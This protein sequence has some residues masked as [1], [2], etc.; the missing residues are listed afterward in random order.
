MATASLRG[1]VD[2]AEWNLR[3]ELAAC[4]RLV[5]LYGMSDLIFTHISAKLEAQTGEEQF[6]INPYGMLFNEITA[7]SLVR[8]D[9]HGNTLSDTLLP[10]NRAGFVIHGT[11]HEARPDVACVL[12]THTRA[13]VAVSAQRAG[14]RPLSQQATLVLGS[15][16]YHGYEGIAVRD[17]ERTSLQRDLG[18]KDFMIL[19]NHGLLTVGRTVALAFWRMYTLESACRIQIDALRD[20]DLVEVQPEVLD[21]VTAA[22]AAVAHTHPAQLAWPALLRQLDHAL[23]GYDH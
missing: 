6:L 5:A 20:G 9:R 23:P 18:D 7:S 13:G 2:D 8:I 19:R 1:R 22:V 3:V 11:I 16:S 17:D 12:H 21:G 15:L 4:Y 10:V 14:L